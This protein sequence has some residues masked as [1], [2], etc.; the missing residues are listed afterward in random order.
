MAWEN[1]GSRAER[2][3]NGGSG[4]MVG[5]VIT[6]GAGKRGV[7]QIDKKYYITSLRPLKNGSGAYLGLLRRVGLV[8]PSV[9]VRVAESPEEA[10]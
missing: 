9:C 5:Y 4:K 1:F 3:I 2:P 7:G 6:T 10:P 8:M